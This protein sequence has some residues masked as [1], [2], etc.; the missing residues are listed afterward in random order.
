MDEADVQRAIEPLVLALNADG[1][2]VRVVEVDGRRVELRLSVADASCA[3]CVMPGDV[4]EGLFLDAL[5]TA[6]HQV[7]RLRLDDPRPPDVAP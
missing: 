4:L 5:A 2:D 6:G 7:E 1:A 3:E